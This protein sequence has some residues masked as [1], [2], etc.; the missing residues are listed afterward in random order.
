MNI[1]TCNFSLWEVVFAFILI[2]RVLMLALTKT[3]LDLLSF[4]QE[5]LNCISN[6]H[7][8][9]TWLNSIIE[10]VC[11]KKFI[12]VL[13]ILIWTA[14]CMYCNVCLFVCRPSPC[15]DKACSSSEVQWW[16]HTSVGDRHRSC[17]LITT[18]K[19][20]KTQQVHW[21]RLRIRGR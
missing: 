18:Q 16:W 11:T 8:F 7:N 19:V 10:Q 21:H 20:Y 9:S 17:P 6:K 14:V 12:I 5:V 1:D 4:L 13:G 2:T 3:M 15:I